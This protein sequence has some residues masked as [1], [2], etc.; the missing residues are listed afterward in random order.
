[1]FN[2]KAELV[3]LRAIWW[4]HCVWHSASMNEN[5][6]NTQ[7]KI[8]SFFQMLCIQIDYFVFYT[9]FLLLKMKLGILNFN[10]FTELTWYLHDLTVMFCFVCSLKGF[11]KGYEAQ[12]FENIQL[13]Q[14]MCHLMNVQA[15]PHNGTWA[16][17]K[18]ML[19]PKS[20]ASLVLDTI[21]LYALSLSLVMLVIK[22]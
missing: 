22:R 17:V 20:Q 15:S 18:D 16:V 14:L 8:K 2:R 11:K 21:E 4:I 19:M 1:M 13:Y 9:A 7:Q 12:G 3:I 10:A 5:I 6:Y